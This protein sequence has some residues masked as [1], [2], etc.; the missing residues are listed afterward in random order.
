MTLALTLTMTLTLALVVVQKRAGLSMPGSMR[1][2]SRSN[3]K[4][5]QHISANIAR[6]ARV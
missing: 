4:D 1:A 3:L 2:R 6:Q 5:A